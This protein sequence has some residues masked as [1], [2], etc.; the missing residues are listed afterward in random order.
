MPRST[1][2]ARRGGKKWPSR[3]GFGTLSCGGGGGTAVRGGKKESRAPPPAHLAVG[4][5][6]ERVA[7]RRPPN[8]ER[9]LAEGDGPA[10]ADPVAARVQ[11]RRQLVGVARAAA[12]V[13]WDVHGDLLPTEGVRAS[14]RKVRRQRH[15]CSGRGEG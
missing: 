3:A 9:L 4:E 11:L 2:V 1:I 13:R 12:E 10:A 6:A 15:V 7:L 8:H 14:P 5:V